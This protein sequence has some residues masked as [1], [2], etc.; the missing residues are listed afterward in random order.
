[1][2]TVEAIG[3]VI[4]ALVGAVVGGLL[5]YKTSI[6]ISRRQEF[7][8]AA[9]SFREAFMPERLALDIHHAPEENEHKTAYEIIE[10]AIQKQTEAMFR[11]AHYLPWW[12][13]RGFIKAWDGYA[14]DSPPG[15]DEPDTPF[16]ALYHERK[17]G[18]EARD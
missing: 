2:W 10:P 6:N 18:K 4:A 13:R 1:M 3:A 16:F 8:K 15:G 7:N 12:Q 17:D 5:T 11:F 9:A 14:H